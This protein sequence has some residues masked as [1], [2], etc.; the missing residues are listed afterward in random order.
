MLI[1]IMVEN[2]IITL[3]ITH[4]THQPQRERRKKI[5]ASI[6]SLAVLSIGNVF[7]ALLLKMLRPLHVKN[8]NSAIK[9]V[10]KHNVIQTHAHSQLV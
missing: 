7:H 9:K 2:I 3:I 4:I 6:H 10:E 1:I 8:I 5:E